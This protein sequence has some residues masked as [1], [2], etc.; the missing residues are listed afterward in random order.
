MGRQTYRD[1]ETFR[2]VS[3]PSM[4]RTT[5]V[6]AH[7]VPRSTRTCMDL[8]SSLLPLRVQCR[9]ST[10]G[11]RSAWQNRRA[12]SQ[13]Q[14]PKQYAPARA[15]VDNG[16]FAAALAL[17]MRANR[18]ANDV[19][20]EKLLVQLRHDA[21]DASARAAP[22]AIPP[23]ISADASTPGPLPE[24]RSRRADAGDLAGRLASSGLRPRARLDH[25]GSC[26]RTRRRHR[27]GT[28]RLRRRG[29]RRIRRRDPA[30]VRP[31]RAQ[32]GAVQGRRTAELGP[33]KWGRLD[34]GLAAHAVRTARHDRGDGYRRDRD[35]VSR[36]TPGAVG[37]QVHAA[38]GPPHFQHRLASG[39]CLSRDERTNAERLVVAVAL[40]PR[41]RPVST[42]CLAASTTSRR[43]GPK[44]PSST[45]RWRPQSWSSSAA[46]SRC[47]VPNF[48]LVTR[49]L[50]DH[51]FL[52]RTAIGPEMTHERYA[53][54]TWFFAPSVY[55]DG[56]IPLLY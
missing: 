27:P 32:T 48:R 7:S 39:R 30:V 26:G 54:E 10:C 28:G 1:C 29:R 40:R 41:T 24:T 5:S 15:L 53:I 47:S 55:P 52:H 50:F 45:G 56:Q 21:F 17:L 35:R 11:T 9:T 34:R 14:R 42:S 46:T 44:V 23:P 3:F 16:D 18:A 33:G 19:A 4:I 36:R 38:K 37:Q 51:M 20:I 2:P 31:V 8:G 12:R 6:A 49:L 43:R 22:A 13:R 25:S